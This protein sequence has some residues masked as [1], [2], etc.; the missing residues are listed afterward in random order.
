MIKNYPKKYSIRK[1]MQEHL[2][3]KDTKD[4]LKIRGILAICN[5]KEDLSKIGGDYYFSQKDYTDLKS[6]MDVEQNYKKSG[7]ILFPKEHL[8]S[9]QSSLE[10]FGN[11]YINR[12]DN[13]KLRVLK[14]ADG[15]TNVLLT[16]DEYKP[17]MIDLLDTTTREVEIKL[18]THG[19]NCSLDFNIQAVSDY[20]KVK[21]LIKYIADNDEDIQFEFQEISLDKLNKSSRIELFERFFKTLIKPW[22]LVEIKKLKV[23]RNEKERKIDADQLE[24]INSAVLDGFNLKENSFVKSTLDKGFYFSMASMRLNETT[25]RNFIDLV[26]DFKT[27]PEMCEVKITHSG[28]Y[29]PKENGDGLIE[30]KKVMTSTEQEELLLEYKNT[31]YEIFLELSN[32][33]MV[34]VEIIASN[35]VASSIE[36]HM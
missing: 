25:S 28:I 34:N 1:V 11:S 22:K 31:L 14:N 17:S 20:K 35:E 32:I 30:M 26:I 19:A 8:D 23:K 36:D 15:T 12:E 29:M 5:K 6:R 16:Y 4:F 18:N 7:R 2:S 27:K 21:E 13:T 9:L 3:T 24:G 33:P 10:L